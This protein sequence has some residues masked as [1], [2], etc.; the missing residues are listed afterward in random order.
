MSRPGSIEPRAHEAREPIDD[1]DVV[2]HGLAEIEVVALLEDAIAD[3]HVADALEAPA[4]A[5]VRLHQHHRPED[6]G[7]SGLHDLVRDL[8]VRARGRAG[9]ARKVSL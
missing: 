3:L 1:R 6:G 4:L 5:A 7:L 2:V 9:E 8:E